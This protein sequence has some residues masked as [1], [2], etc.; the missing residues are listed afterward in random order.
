MEIAPRFDCPSLKR[1]YTYKGISYWDSKTEYLN[2]Q[3]HLLSPT[4][5]Q[6]AERQVQGRLQ[7][8]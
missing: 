4:F 7:H 5:K 8:F 2:Y 6:S 1:S 3:K